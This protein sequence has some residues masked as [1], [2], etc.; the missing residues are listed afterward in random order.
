LGCL[1]ETGGDAAELLELAEAALD[2]VTLRVEVG[3]DR[4][5]AGPRGIVWD[6]GLGTFCSDG[7]ADVVGV[8]SGISDDDLGGCA[9]EEK[10]SLRSIAGLACG[11]DEI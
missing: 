7:A 1:L 4:V 8:V 9:I 3:V 10:S 11:E 5:L 2:E 6:D